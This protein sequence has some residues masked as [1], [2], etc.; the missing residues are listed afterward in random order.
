MSPCAFNTLVVHPPSGVP[1]QRSD[2]AVAVP[3]VLGCQVDDVPGQ[4]LVVVRDL[5]PRTLC[6][7]WLS[8]YTAGFTFRN[9][10]PVP[11]VINVLTAT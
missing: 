9:M 7:S 6:S 10:E 11:D 5:R 1:E 8:Q 2:P 3:V 4:E